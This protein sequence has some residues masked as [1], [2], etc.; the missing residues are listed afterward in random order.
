MELF[1][2]FHGYNRVT[3]K[4]ASLINCIRTKE[5]IERFCFVR[6]TQKFMFAT[7]GRK[8][9]RIEIDVDTKVEHGIYFMTKDRILLKVDY[10]KYPNIDGIFSN[11]GF[12]KTATIELE[13]PI[14]AM[15]YSMFEF[16][17]TI[18][19]DFLADTFDAIAKLD[20]VFVRMYGYTE[21]HEEDP[22]LIEIGLE[23][24]TIHCAF[25]PMKLQKDT[26]VKVDNQPYLFDMKKAV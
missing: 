1:E 18:N 5:D 21:K 12:T 26:V 14:T 8:A 15:A 4:I 10:D 16:N 7:D 25:M 23:K 19:L 6:I 17:T 13:N 11:T 22:V 2:D 3:K 24:L 20:P 9:V